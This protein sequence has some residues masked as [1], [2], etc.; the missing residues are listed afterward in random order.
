MR[1]MYIL[2]RYTCHPKCKIISVDCY[3][4]HNISIFSPHSN[5]CG[6]VASA[7]ACPVV[8]SSI[9]STVNYTSLKL[10]DTILAELIYNSRLGATGIS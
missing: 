10:A 3:K 8:M 9:F 2:E 6:P 5:P 1:R 7:W 4:K